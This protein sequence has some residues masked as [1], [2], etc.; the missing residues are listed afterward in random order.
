MKLLHKLSIALLSVSMFIITL[1]LSLVPM[2]NNEKFF[3]NIWEKAGVYEQMNISEDE[4]TK[5]INHTMDYMWDKNDDLQITVTLND[6]TTREFYTDYGVSNGV[7]YNELEHMRECKVLFMAGKALMIIACIT[8]AICLGFLLIDKKHQDYKN[9]RVSY[10]TYA[11]IF[12]L[13][14][15]FGIAVISNFDQAFDAF[16]DIFFKGSNVSYT[17]PASSFMIM[18][19]PEE[20]MFGTIVYTALGRFV[21]IFIL[22]IITTIIAQKRLKRK[23]TS[24]QF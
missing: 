5:V 2:I 14:I 18:M 6:N 20:E 16:H 10:I 24:H 22:I 12:L 21:G 19:L 1:F 9:L 3:Q 7:S 23:E 8:A 11:L 13:I 4:L 15:L 17:Y